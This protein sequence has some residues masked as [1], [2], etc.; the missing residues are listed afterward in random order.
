MIKIKYHF[1]GFK[2]I[3]ECPNEFRP[4]KDS[5]IYKVASAACKYHCPHF[6]K[7]DEKKKEVYCKFEKEN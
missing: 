2:A 6:V 5:I 7:I 1:D 3:I 4:F